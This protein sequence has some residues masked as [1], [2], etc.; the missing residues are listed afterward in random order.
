MRQT[1][2]TKSS[3][4]LYVTSLRAKVLLP[5]DLIRPSR[6]TAKGSQ[7]V[8]QSVFQ[9]RKPRVR[10]HK[11]LSKTTGPVSD[12]VQVRKQT[13][14]LQSGTVTKGPE[15]SFKKKNSYSDMQ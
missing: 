4:H 12:K 15:H 8:V 2:Q 13:S 14:G 7:Y 6:T 11:D 5:Q 3:L 9:K 1:D 10:E